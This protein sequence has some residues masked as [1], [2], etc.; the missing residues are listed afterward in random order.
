MPNRL[1]LPLG[2][3][4][5]SVLALGLM[6]CGDDGGTSDAADEV[7]TDGSGTAGDGDGDPTTTGD[8]DGD[9]TTTG[10]GDGD[11]TT[12]GD[13]DGDGDPTTTGD[14]DGDG[15]CM[16]WEITYDLTGSEFELANTPANGAGDQVNTV[17]EPYD[18]DKTV[19]PGHFV[20]QFQ[21]VGGNPGGQAFMNSYE[22]GMHFLVNSLGT[23]VATDLDADAGPEE[24]GITSGPLDASI[25]AWS[26]STIVGLH[27]VGEILCNGLGCM[28]ANLP[29]GMAVPQDETSDM[30]IS[31]FV[32]S[33]DMTGFTMVKTVI[34]MDANS[35]T[36][37]KYTG[38]ET[39]RELVAAPACLCE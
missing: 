12:T 37:W 21:D 33:G 34:Q 15:D 38:T 35:T 20:L 30:P 2:L 23:T 19:G 27:T 5:A 24:C 4:S 8:G 10:D 16:V 36:S 25:V 29:N 6:A 17:A 32:F 1:S 9:P 11:P 18:A 13:G 28:F 3:I 7:G 31:N 39:S 26:P 22:M 14:G